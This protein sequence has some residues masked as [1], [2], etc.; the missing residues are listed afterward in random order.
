MVKALKCMEMGIIIKDH[1]WM[2][3]PKDMDA[4]IGKMVALL[5]EI[6]NKV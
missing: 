2:E 4:I 6:L 1:L 5:R 3:C